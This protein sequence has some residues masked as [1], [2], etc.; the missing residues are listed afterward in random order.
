[1]PP[2]HASAIIRWHDQLDA[3][4]GG[5]EAFEHSATVSTML[6]GC[7][8]WLKHHAATASAEEAVRM[9]QITAELEKWMGVRGLT[10]TH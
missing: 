6:F 8:S 10:F 2:N 1:M 5:L 7:Y 4:G 3:L 9:H